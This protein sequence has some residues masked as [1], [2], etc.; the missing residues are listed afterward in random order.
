MSDDPR[1]RERAAARDDERDSDVEGHKLAAFREGQEDVVTDD[2]ERLS[3]RGEGEGDEAA[4][5]R[6]S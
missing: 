6:R 4:D 1:D 5:P 3:G 2:E